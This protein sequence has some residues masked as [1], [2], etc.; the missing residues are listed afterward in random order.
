MPDYALGADDHD[1]TGDTCRHSLSRRYRDTHRTGM[2]E[3]AG[4][5]GGG[6]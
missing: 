4:Y 2:P 3:W 6:I 1:H 5:H